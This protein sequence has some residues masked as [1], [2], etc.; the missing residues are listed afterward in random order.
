MDWIFKE[1]QPIYTQIIAQLKIKIANGTYKPGEKL[2]SVRE[3][4]LA[5]AVNPNT[6]QRALA[7]MERECLIFAERTNG[8]FVTEG[9]EVLD[10]LKRTL[11]EEFI[12]DLF[13]NLKKIGLDNE[14][15]I[16]AVNQWAKEEQ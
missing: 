15:I 8:R 7:E 14:E 16:A 9:G 12:G 4:A 6:M 10:N 2:P 5:A 13:Q 1:G 3:L 11:A